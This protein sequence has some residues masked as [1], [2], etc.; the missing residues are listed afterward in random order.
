MVPLLSPLQSRFSPISL[1]FLSFLILSLSIHLHLLSHLSKGPSHRICTTQDLPVGSVR[2]SSRV[3]R[4]IT[5]YLSH[6]TATSI[7]AQR[8]LGNDLLKLSVVSL[9][10]VVTPHIQC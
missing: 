8:P 10:L 7:P 2:L 9:Y 5:L 6:H 4:T 3:S 1:S